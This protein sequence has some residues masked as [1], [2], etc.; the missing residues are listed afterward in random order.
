MDDI[1]SQ[2]VLR[3]TADYTYLTVDHAFPFNERLAFMLLREVMESSELE[4]VEELRILRRAFRFDVEGWIVHPP[5][6]VGIVEET[7]IRVYDSDD[8]VTEGELLDTYVHEAE[9]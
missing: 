1:N 4:P 2:I 9:A 8:L 5:Y 7:T 3:L 6:E